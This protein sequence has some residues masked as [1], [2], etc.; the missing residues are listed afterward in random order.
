MK[1]INNKKVVQGLSGRRSSIP[2]K[3]IIFLLYSFFTFSVFSNFLAFKDLNFGAV[4]LPHQVGIL[5]LVTFSIFLIILSFT[6]FLKSEDSLNIFFAWVIV[7]SGSAFLRYTISDDIAF[8]LF[9]LFIL[10]FRIQSITLIKKHNIHKLLLSFLLLQIVMSIYGSFYSFYAVRFLLIFVSTV[11]VFQFISTK[12]DKQFISM[13][14]A[15]YWPVI[16]YVFMCFAWWFGIHSYTNPSGAVLIGSLEGIGYAGTSHKEIP[17]IFLSLASLVKFH[18][19]S[20]LRYLLIA[21][22]LLAAFVVIADSRLATM[23]L[24]THL[25]SVFLINFRIWAQLMIFSGTITLI[26]IL[27]I[28]GDLSSVTNYI[29]GFIRIFS[30]SADTT[31]YAYRNT[32]ITTQTGDIGRIFFILAGFQYLIF[33]FPS[34]LFGCGIYGFYGCAQPYLIDVGY[35]AFTNLTG[36]SVDTWNSTGLTRAPFL[37]SVIVETGILGFSLLIFLLLSP[38]FKVK[39]KIKRIFFIGTHFILAIAFCIAGYL[40]DITIYF[41]AFAFL[42]RVANS[43]FLK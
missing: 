11:V 28:G 26:I 35:V 19:T 39:G 41:V 43:I 2:K 21:T 30:S 25:F 20:L 38:F 23:I 13:I 29:E 14:E 42:H 12:S 27:V 3:S 17:L 4:V 7:L 10:F 33:E 40:S 18:R 37:P 5:Q 8:I 16:F 22:M 15:A 31:S 6:F 36:G 32:T 9:A 34:S 1:I 24:L